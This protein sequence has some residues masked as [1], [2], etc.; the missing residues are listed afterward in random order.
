MTPNL[1]AAVDAAMVEMQ[2]IHPPLK[3]SECERLIHAALSAKAAPAE[4]TEAVEVVGYLYAVCGDL[5]LDHQ[6]PNL[7]HEQLM[8]VAQ[9]K[10]LMAAKDGDVVKVPRE[11]MERLAIHLE[12]DGSPEIT[13]IQYAYSCDRLA[14]ELRALL[15]GAG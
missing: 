8:T 2:N 7:P 4:P 1:I 12:W 13:V 15:G 9:H 14:E 5:L 10:R 11:L 3:R 6:K